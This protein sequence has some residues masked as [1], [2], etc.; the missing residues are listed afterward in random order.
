MIH[1]VV[2]V[3]IIFGMYVLRCRENEIGNEA[4][5]HKFMFIIITRSRSAT[6]IR[7]G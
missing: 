7:R 3:V 6:I 4:L 5:A 2:Y 1:C